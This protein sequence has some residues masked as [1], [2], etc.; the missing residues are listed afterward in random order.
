MLP[1]EKDI[2]KPDPTMENDKVVV[3]VIQEDGKDIEVVSDVPPADRNRKPLPADD[4][5]PTEEEL[6]SYSE[7]VRRRI[8][9]EI[10]RAH[11][12]RRAKEAAA[13]ER[14]EAIA[15]AQR[16][17]QEKKALEQRYKAG[18][19]AFITQTKEKVTL[20]M[21]E[22][23]RAY[24][25]AYESGD[26]DAMA[27]AQEKIAEAKLEQQ[28]AEEWSRQAA[29]RKEESAR[30]AEE[31]VV[32]SRQSQQVR[33]PEPDPEAVDWA[34]K[35]KWFGTNKVMTSTAYGIHDELVEQG[36][37]PGRDASEYYKKLNARMREIFPA[38]E[39]GDTPK[40]P[41]SVVAPVSRTSKTAT[42]VKLTQSQ[43]AVAKRLGLT[44]L[45][46]AT[47]LA[48]LENN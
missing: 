34:A 6:E 31:D 11:D 48:K 2:I 36:I 14:D 4:K 1:E 24:K 26:A 32:Q 3:E 20:S 46:Y 13:R 33:T 44:P 17:L 38:H 19:D 10:H 45:Q 40:K 41:T 42:R 37:D 35:N 29:Q 28:R 23:K 7:E 5:A 18:E 22:A 43:V 9:K 12:E 15:T 25:A 39:W 16:L 21:A 30:Q 8:G 27:D 47:E